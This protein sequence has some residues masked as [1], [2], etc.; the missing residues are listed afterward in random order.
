LKK[1]IITDKS[2]INQ[3]SPNNAQ[4]LNKLP[5]NLIKIEAEFQEKFHQHLELSKNSYLL[6]MFYHIQLL[7]SC[8]K[9]AI[10]LVNAKAGRKTEQGNSSS[11]MAATIRAISKT[12]RQKAA[13]D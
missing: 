3:H 1:N 4:V 2:L 13:E 5:T 8:I 9:I 12:I 6:R 11:P 7:F 10:I